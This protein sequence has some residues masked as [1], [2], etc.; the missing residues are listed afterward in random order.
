MSEVH[1]FIGDSESDDETVPARMS[2]VAWLLSWFF[3]P[4]L[5]RDKGHLG[6]SKRLQPRVRCVGLDELVEGDELAC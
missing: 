4:R 1:F 2:L 5:D 3:P 6:R